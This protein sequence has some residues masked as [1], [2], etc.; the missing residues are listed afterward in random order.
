M[1]AFES[2]CTD[3]DLENALGGSTRL[4]LLQTIDGALNVEVSKRARMQGA[5]QIDAKAKAVIDPFTWHDSYPP[6]AVSVNIDLAI[7]NM[8]KLTYRSIPEAVQKAYDAALALID[9]IGSSAQW[10]S[11]EPAEK[12]ASRVRWYNPNKPLSSGQ[13]LHSRYS[14]CSETDYL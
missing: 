1:P 7:W 10:D 2:Y 5:E 4:R 13:V 12:V 3:T 11:S 9:D 6:L 14:H 8:Y